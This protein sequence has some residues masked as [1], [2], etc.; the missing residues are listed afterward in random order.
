M[1]LDMYA[2]DLYW[3]LE[4]LYI[5]RFID[6]KDRGLLVLGR[7]PALIACDLPTCPRLQ[8]S[9][10]IVILAYALRTPYISRSF[11]LPL[12]VLYVLRF[13]S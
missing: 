8:P 10:E 13:C 2:A 5:L 12:L 9:L 3:R 7:R 6:M 11:Q 4:R 1:Q